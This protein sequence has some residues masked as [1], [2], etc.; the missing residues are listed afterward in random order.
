MDCRRGE[1]LASTMRLPAMAL[2]RWM[3][4]STGSHR[5]TGAHRLSSGKSSGM[6]NLIIKA[7][8]S[9]RSTVDGHS[10]IQHA[11]S[12]LKL[13][14]A[15]FKS[16]VKAQAEATHCLERWAA[17]EDNL[18]LQDSFAKL[19]EL[20]KLWSDVQI[21]FADQIKEFRQ[22]FE[23]I[24]GQEIALDAA[25]KHQQKCERHEKSCEKEIQKLQRKG[26]STAS[27][28]SRLRQVAS[29]PPLPPPLPPFTMHNAPLIAGSQSAR[30]CGCDCR[31]GRQR[32]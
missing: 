30:T 1:P 28:E 4:I 17:R 5:E 20:S 32:H 19:V 9:W 27:M 24:L 31:H 7:Q 22:V 23:T 6:S 29:S 25:R 21:M 11:I 12:S 16:W 14:K 15:A 13:A 2:S 3:S 8:A 18:A 26:E 10:D